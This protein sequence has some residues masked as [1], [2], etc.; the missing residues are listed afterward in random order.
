M[1]PSFT[2]SAISALLATPS[3]AFFWAGKGQVATLEQEIV[4]L[5]QKLALLESQLDIFADDML[6]VNSKIN[7][8]AEQVDASGSLDYCCTLWEEPNFLGE[9]LSYCLQYQNGSVQTA[10]F[11]ALPDGEL[12]I[13]SYSCGKEI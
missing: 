8:V 1:R 2:L 13:G 10:D 6:A 9:G 11:F 7:T 12:P 4:E 5:Q 3:F